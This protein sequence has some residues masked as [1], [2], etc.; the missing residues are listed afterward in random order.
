MTRAARRLMLEWLIRG[1]TLR[2]FVNERTPRDGDAADDY[3]EMSSGGYRPLG[4]HETDWRT[5]QDR[6]TVKAPLA[7]TFTG[8]GQDVTGWY[9]TRGDVLIKAER[10]DEVFPVRLRDDRLEVK[11]WLELTKGD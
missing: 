2:L 3:T 10:L 9:L 4:I 11:P 1:L 7:F 6:F 5:T 8:S